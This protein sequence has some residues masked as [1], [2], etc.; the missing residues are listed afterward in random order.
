MSE[1]RR[2]V[3]RDHDYD[4]IQEFDNQLPNWWIGTFVV[5]VLFG[6]YYWTAHYTFNSLPGQ[7]ERFVAETK[8][9]TDAQAAHGVGGAVTDEQELAVF[10]DAK[11]VAA[12]KQLFAEKCVACHGA[13]AQGI[14]G[15]NLTD[16]YWLHGGRPS[17]IVATIT[18]GV[19]EKGMVTWKGQISDQQIKEAAA[20]IL[21]IHGSKPAGAKAA[22][23]T[24]E[25]W[26]VK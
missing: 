19:P 10:H 26:D 16:D 3:V 8:E 25:K 5:T 7:H 18:N 14:I 23:G 20:Y 21:S 17:Q 9:I 24:L 12:G 1:E 22:Q 13:N 11:E 4:G 6:L 2:D 15:P